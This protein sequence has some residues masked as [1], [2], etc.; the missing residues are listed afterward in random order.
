VT[1]ASSYYGP[2]VTLLL[3]DATGRYAWDAHPVCQPAA[4]APTTLGDA[5]TATAA[6]G[7]LPTGPGPGGEAALPFPTP[8]TVEQRA[9]LVRDP[10]Y[11]SSGEGRRSAM[12]PDTLCHMLRKMGPVGE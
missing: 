5:A 2:F 12:F 11:R 7:A 9:E 3:R 1:N 8:T 6:A 10:A 4:L